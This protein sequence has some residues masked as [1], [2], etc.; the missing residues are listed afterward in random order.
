VPPEA[1]LGP[2]ALLV[3]AVAA[4]GVLWREHL[5]ADA[6]DRAQRDAFAA[7]LDK[8]LDNNAASLVAWNRRNELEASRQRRGDGKP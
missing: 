6:D 7:L 1:L 4:V 2:F 8:S 3:A 5:K